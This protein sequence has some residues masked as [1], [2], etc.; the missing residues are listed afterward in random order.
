MGPAAEHVEGV[1]IRKSG[2][3]LVEEAPDQVIPKIVDFLN[4]LNR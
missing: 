4:S 2:H 1:V 3:W